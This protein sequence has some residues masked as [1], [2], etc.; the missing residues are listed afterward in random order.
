MKIIFQWVVLALLF[1]G[2]ATVPPGSVSLAGALQTEG[3]RM[4]E[5]NLRLLNNLFAEKRRALENVLSDQYASSLIDHAFELSPNISKA[6]FPDFLKAVTKKLITKRDSLVN[7]LE[8]EKTR[9]ADR[10]NEDY[11]AF[12]TV[13]ISL[14]LMLAS[15]VK[16]DQQR[17]AALDQAKTL[18]NN[19]VD[20]VAIENALDDFI[21]SAGKVGADVSGFKT[22]I[23]GLLKK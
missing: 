15:A 10:L 4:H 18:T 21:N 7:V 23:D 17:Q 14:K 20:F 19:K 8:T 13:S 11:N 2:C 1:A 9:I 5:L 3:T 22:K 16:V 12:T 6:D